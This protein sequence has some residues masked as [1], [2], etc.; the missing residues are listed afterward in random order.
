MARA[1][2]VI[3]GKLFYNDGVTPIGDRDKVTV[4]VRTQAN[5]ILAS[6]D[7]TGEYSLELKPFEEPDKGVVVHFILN[8]KRGR[9]LE[10]VNAVSHCVQNIDIGLEKPPQKS[11]TIRSGFVTVH[12]NLNYTDG[13]TLVRGT[14]RPT[15][16]AEDRKG[17][18]LPA[19]VTICGGAYTVAIDTANIKT[20]DKSFKLFF[21][22][23]GATDHVSDGVFGGECGNPQRMD[24][25]Y[26]TAAPCFE[27]YSPRHGRL[28]GRLFFR[29]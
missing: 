21:M 17:K 26:S 16:A 7:F 14:D 6:Q 20:Q 15:I 13:R 27:P 22:L 24:I 23:N 9:S 29:R 10:G 19:C 4:E 28:G 12:G 1:Q 5:T 11:D 3:R 8:G 25:A 18:V 2:T